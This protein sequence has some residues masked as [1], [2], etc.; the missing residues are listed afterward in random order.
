MI[1]QKSQAV[2]FD[3]FF[4]SASV[5]KT[6]LSPTVDV[7]DE[8]GNLIVSA[9]S[10]TTVGGG[11]YTYT[12]TGGNTGD[13]GNYRAIF[14]TTDTSVDQKQLPGLWVVG[15]TWAEN[16]NA[17]VSSRSSHSATDIW[18]VGTRTLTGFGMLVAD[19]ATEVWGAATRTLSAFGFNVTVATNNDKTGYALTSAYDP[20]KTAAQG[21]DMV[22]VLATVG[23][24]DATTSSTDGKVDALQTSVNGLNDISQAEVYSQV[25][26][27]IAA[28]TLATGADVDALQNN[29][30]AILDGANGVDPGITV[31]QA[32]RACLSALAGTN[33]GAG[34]TNIEYKSTDGSKTRISATVDSV[35]NRSNVVLDVT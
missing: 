11:L 9:A 12:L 2:V 18:A 3:A 8:S 10:A 17:T 34:T 30:M 7:Y 6:G 24:I 20:A 23:T 16:V 33:T 22:E 5:G 21:V 4:T 29:I 31:R 28:A 1:Q 32:L 26:T 13:A 19:I 25:S 14:K 15:P 27:A 35:G